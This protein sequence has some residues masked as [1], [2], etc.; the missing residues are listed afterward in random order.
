MQRLHPTFYVSLL[1]L[2]YA[3]LGYNPGLVLMLLKEGEHDE[4]DI[5]LGDHYKIKKIVAY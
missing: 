1:E 2:Y 4:T 5:T 3:Q